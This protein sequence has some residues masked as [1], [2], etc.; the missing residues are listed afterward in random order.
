MLSK[1]G[2]GLMQ[3]FNAALDATDLW[4]QE[5]L[6]AVLMTS[7]ANSCLEPPILSRF[8]FIAPLMQVWLSLTP[9]GRPG[10][11]PVASVG[12]RKD[13]PQIDPGF[14]GSEPREP[15]RVMASALYHQTHPTRTPRRARSV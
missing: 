13:R 12:S 10:A 6:L 4:Q 5:V 8:L 9:R 15:C 2:L 7:S 3:G 14:V 1:I 11:G